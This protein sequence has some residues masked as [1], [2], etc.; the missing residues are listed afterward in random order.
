MC[1]RV[2]GAEGLVHSAVCIDI[3]LGVRYEQSVLHKLRTAQRCM[4][5]VLSV[6]RAVV[7]EDLCMTILQEMPG[8]P[9]HRWQRMRPILE[10]RMARWIGQP[11]GMEVQPHC[12]VEASSRVDLSL[13]A[14]SA[15]CVARNLTLRAR[16]RA[17]CH[18]G[19]EPQGRQLHHLGCQ[20]TRRCFDTS[21]SRREYTRGA[22]M[23][24]GVREWDSHGDDIGRHL[25]RA[26][27]RQ[28]RNFRFKPRD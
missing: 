24:T 11:I 7:R 15:F 22:Y 8:R 1:G 20:T 19:A 10:R 16:G 26:M 21:Q 6:M 23:F 27:W 9:E 12:D 25:E 14:Q 4:A 13:I 28:L 2:L 3:K 5:G 18:C 17:M